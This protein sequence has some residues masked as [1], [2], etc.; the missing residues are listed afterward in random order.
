MC[1]LHVLEHSKQFLKCLTFGQ[2]FFL[3]WP[4]PLG[5]RSQKIPKKSEIISRVDISKADS[6][7]GQIKIDWLLVLT[8]AHVE[9]IPLITF[10]M[11]D[12]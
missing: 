3:G 5:V 1:L 8:V 2:N 4:A 11:E 6:N 10:C 7:A 9:P 12:D